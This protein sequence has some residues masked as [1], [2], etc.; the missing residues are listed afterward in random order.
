MIRDLSDFRW[1]E[2]IKTDLAKWDR[3]RKCVY[4]KDHGHTMEQCR[5]LYYLVE[6]L[7]KAG[8]LKQYVRTSEGQREMTRDLAT[9]APTTSTTPR[10]VINY[11]HGGPVDEKYNSKHKRQRLLRVASVRKQVSSIQHSLLGG[12]DAQWTR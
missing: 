7:I 1:L 8:H 9:Q 10:D 5:S 6:R 12:V 2:P 11:I 4:H 3:S